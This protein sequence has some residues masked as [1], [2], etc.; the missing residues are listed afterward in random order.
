MHGL[1]G[2]FCSF[3]CKKRGWRSIFLS[4]DRLLAD[5]P[6]SGV[7]QYVTAIPK[8]FLTIPMPTAAV[9][10]ALAHSIVP[11]ACIHARTVAIA[12]GIATIPR[13]FLLLLKNTLAQRRRAQ[14]KAVLSEEMACISRFRKPG[15]LQGN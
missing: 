10:G 6:E 11:K 9:A 8:F 2:K 3:A 15:T 12:D 1:S 4:R 13:Q 7:I 5:D 14:I